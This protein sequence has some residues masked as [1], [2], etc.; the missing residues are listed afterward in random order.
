M[1]SEME[2]ITKRMKSEINDWRLSLGTMSDENII[3]KTHLSA[4]LKEN[5]DIS[6]L[7]QVENLYS[8]LLTE[9]EFINLLRHNIGELDS[10]IDSE[11]SKSLNKNRFEHMCSTLQ[12][13]MTTARIRLSRLKS[14]FN[15]FFQHGA[16]VGPFQTD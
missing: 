6:L 11:T 9:E 3:M 15:D 7:P 10:L 14:E 13:Q 12:S 2:E 4:I 1:L 16:G 8:H 5:F